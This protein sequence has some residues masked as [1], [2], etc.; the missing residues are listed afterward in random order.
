[1][2]AQNENL[3]KTKANIFTKPASD[4]VTENLTADDNKQGQLKGC[5]INTRLP[6]TQRGR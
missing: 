4:L 2:S 3:A 1:M 5:R 6:S